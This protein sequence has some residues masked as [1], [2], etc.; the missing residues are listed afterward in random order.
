MTPLSGEIVMGIDFGNQ[1]HLD[2][3]DLPDPTYPTLSANDGARHLIDPAIRLGSRIDGESDGQPTA[4]ADGDGVDEDGVVFVTDF[5]RTLTT[6]IDVTAS[7]PGELV[8]W[9]DF[10]RSGT[11]DNATERFTHTFTAAGTE[12]LTVDVP[13]SAPSGDSAARFRFSTD[14]AA[15]A[16]PTGFAPDGEVEDYAIH[17]NSLPP[18]I[19]NLGP[20]KVFEEDRPAVQMIPNA[21]VSDPDTPV[22]DGGQLVA[23]ILNSEAG[24]ILEVATVGTV[25]TSAGTTVGSDVSVGGTIVGTISDVSGGGVTI[26]FNS[27]ATIAAVQS[28][29]RAIAFNNPLDNPVP[30]TRSVQFIVADGT[31]ADSGP[32]TQQVSVLSRPDR[33][34]ISNLGGPVTFVE[35]AGPISLTTTG[36]LSDPDQH[37]DWGGARLNVQ[38]SRNGDSFD[39]LTI[40]NQGTGAGQIGVSGT[41]VTYEGAVIGNFNGGIGSVRLQINFVAGATEAAVQALIRAIEFENLNDSP[42]VASKDVQFSITDPQGFANFVVPNGLLR[43]NMQATNDVPV[44]AGFS[45]AAFTYNEGDPPRTIGTGSTLTDA[46]YNGGG[47]LTVAIVGGETA[48]RLTIFTQG[49]GPNQVS[50]TGNQVRYS[51]VLIGTVSGGIG[52]NPMVVTFNNNATRSGVEAVMRLVQFSNIS[53]NPLTTQRQVGFVF[54][55]GDAGT[56][57]TGTVLVNVNG[58]NDAPVLTNFGGDVSTATGT[59]VRVSSGFTLSDIDSPNFDGGMFRATIS[60]GQQAGDLFSLFNDATISVVGSSVFYL[61]ANIGTLSTNATS[62]TVVLNANS[63]PAAVQRL[64]RNL[65]FTAGTAGARS[66]H[67]QVLDG[68]GANV[69]TA[70]KSVNI[71]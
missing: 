41:D 65:E 21:V 7:A 39:R 43:V 24:D 54:N 47:N 70:D 29:L 16:D 19:T 20:R 60:A 15:I 56:S 36:T 58:V 4:A 8:F 51:G 30:G 63:S 45:A 68:D 18:S 49:N 17:I 10:D 55:D 28:V 37:P 50:L 42:I 27:N 13:A 53:D 69:S 31:G 57:N 35:G 61:G 1:V 44:L 59:A 64:G 11:F 34:V 48:D 38:V 26:D 22:F 66:V 23:T 40:A 3:G 6:T 46:D 9:I 62:L 33:P 52:T 67:Y 71:T 5:V 25:T 12:S 2:F 14:G 32:V